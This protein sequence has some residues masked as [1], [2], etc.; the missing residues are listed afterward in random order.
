VL[1]AGGAVADG[2]DVLG[3]LDDALRGGAAGVA[4]GRHVF[5]AADP[6]AVV[7]KISGLVHDS[8]RST[9]MGGRS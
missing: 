5:Q 4:V 3:Q 7:R 1:V 8:A 2:A 9:A 6:G